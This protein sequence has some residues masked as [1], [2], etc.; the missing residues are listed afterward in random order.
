MPLIV[1][2]SGAVTPTPTP[3]PPIIEQGQTRLT[4]WAPDGTPEGIEVPLSRP[5]LGWR[6]M[7]GVRGLGQ[8][9]GP[10]LITLPVRVGGTTTGQFVE[11]LDHLID[12]F[13]RTDTDG[14]G[15]L[16]VARPDGRRRE[17]LA[18][19]QSGL[20]GDRGTGATAELLVITLYCPVPWFRDV[21]PVRIERRPAVTRRYLGPAYP[22]LSSGRALGQSIVHNPGN[23]PAW[24]VW[25]VHGPATVLTASSDRLGGAGFTLTL[26]DPLGAGEVATVDTDPLT[27]SIT[28]PTGDDLFGDLDWPGATLFPLLP[29]ANPVTFAVTGGGWGELTYQPRYRSA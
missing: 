24:P 16:M 13:G 26:S 6:L 20:D 8:Y 10:R 1:R 23:V 22:A 28:G 7:R 12:V 19:T 17:I 2:A 29:G 11:R 15:R 27:G 5:S 25:R 3:P 14:P 18:Y 4:W 21:T 9:T